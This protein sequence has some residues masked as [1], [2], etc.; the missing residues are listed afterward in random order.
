[1]LQKKINTTGIIFNY[2]KENQGRWITTA[3][4]YNALEL[5]IARKTVHHTFVRLAESGYVERKV[6]NGKITKVTITEKGM[7]YPQWFLA[8]GNHK[9]LLESARHRRTLHLFTRHHSPL[10]ITDLGVLL[11]CKSSE[12]QHAFR[13]FTLL[14]VLKEHHN[15]GWS[16]SYSYTV[17]SKD[18]FEVLL[19]IFE[20]DDEDKAWLEDSG[21]N[22]TYF[23]QYQGVVGNEKLKGANSSV[24]GQ[25]FQYL[26]NQKEGGA[27]QVL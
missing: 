14:G 1:M 7:L 16:P 23:K 18:R 3:E 5:T 25:W 6:V 4:T 8:N 12:A 2:L 21:R 24:M 26:L 10:N 15:P 22:H 11:G 13:T 27:C 20:L 17:K 19:K 9:A